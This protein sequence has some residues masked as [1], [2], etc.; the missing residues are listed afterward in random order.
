M[1]ELISSA[2]AQAGAPAT[3]AAVGNILFMV[4]LFAIFY[5]LLIRPQQKQAKEHKEMVANLRRGD[6][7]VTG[8][9]MVGR[10]HRVEDDTVTVEVGDVEVGPRSFKPVRIK[11]KR[12]TIT[13]VNVK[14]AVAPAEEGSA[15]Q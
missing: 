14:A 7:V 5:F 12:A 13:A 8:G 4:I 3:G 1:I 9:G 15:D 10:I 2:H 11:V 6:S